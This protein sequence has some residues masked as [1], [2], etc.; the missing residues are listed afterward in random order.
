M[1]HHQKAE[2]DGGG[3][4]GV[5]RRG[6]YGGYWQLLLLSNQ[7]ILILCQCFSIA[8][9]VFGLRDAVLDEAR[10]SIRSRCAAENWDGHFQQ[11]SDV[12]RTTQPGSEQ[13]HTSLLLLISWLPTESWYHD[14]IWSSQILQIA[15]KATSKYRFMEVKTNQTTR[16]KKIVK[17]IIMRNNSSRNNSFDRQKMYWK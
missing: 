1:S 6:G 14:D 2:Q 17:K 13:P 5:G 16:W 10:H 9:S 15:A 3:G 12:A 8:I 7:P 4:G 11:L